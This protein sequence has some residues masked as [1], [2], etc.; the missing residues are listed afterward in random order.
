MCGEKQSFRKI[1]AQGTGKECRQVVQK[2]NMINGNLKC[3]MLE[4]GCLQEQNETTGI[5]N[6]RNVE[7]S[8]ANQTSTSKWNQFV[9]SVTSDNAGKYYKSAEES[10]QRKLNFGAL[11][12]IEKPIFL[13]VTK[14][15]SQFVQTQYQLK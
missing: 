1:F 14:V 11:M 6:H 12:L 5:D 15:K 13:L 7:K 10:Q 9:S 2:L 3:R 4:E 8:T